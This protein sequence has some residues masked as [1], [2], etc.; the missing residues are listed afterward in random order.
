MTQA[1]EVIVNFHRQ[2][3]HNQEIPDFPWFEKPV[4]FNHSNYKSHLK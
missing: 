2:V 1:S 4:I 3:I